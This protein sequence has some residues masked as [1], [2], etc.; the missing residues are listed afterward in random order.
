VLVAPVLIALAAWLLLDYVER[1]DGSGWWRQVSLGDIRQLIQWARAWGVIFA[2]G[3]MVRH[4]FVPFPAEFVAIANGIV[5]GPYWGTVI[6][7]TG[8]QFRGRRFAGACASG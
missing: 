6:T 2:V 7:W 5:C 4:S 1:D 3:L 8:A